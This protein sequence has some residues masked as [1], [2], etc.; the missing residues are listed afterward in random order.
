ML[1][2]DYYVDAA[3]DIL[4]L[5]SQLDE[6]V[7][8]DMV[9]RMVRMGDVTSATVWQAE[10]LQEAGMLYDDIIRR[11]AEIT[12][13]ST[14]QVQ[15]MFEDAGIRSIEYDAAIYERAGLTPVPIR[16]SPEAAQRLLAGIRKTQGHLGNLSLTTATTAQSAYIQAVTLAEMQ[17]E[18]GVM[19]YATAIRNAVRSAAEQGTVVLYPTGHRDK[20]DVA[21]RRAVLTGA[22]QTASQIS[23][24]YAADMGCDLVETTAHAGARPS[25]AVW[26]GRVFSISGNHPRYGDF[27]DATGYGTGGGLCGWNCRHS[28]F[29][30]FEGLSR[31]TYGRDRLQEYDSRTVTYNGDTMPYYDAT[32]VQRGLERKVRDTKRTLA[33]LDEGVKSADNDK[34]RNA[35]RKEFEAESVRLKS[36]EAKLKD[37]LAQTDL[38]RQKER[39]QVLAWGRSTAQKAVWADRRVQ[40][41]RADDIIIAEAKK[42]SGIRGKMELHPKTTDMPHMTVDTEHIRKRG[43][44]VTAE[45]AHEY[46]ANARVKVT[47]WGG[48]FENYYSDGGAAYVD[49]ANAQ[50]R[51]AFSAEEYADTMKAMM[52]GLRKHGK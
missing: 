28:F 16:Q 44:E 22:S 30:F 36:Q 2:P 23:L 15:A 31:R 49:V 13:A 37:F 29:P 21:V 9:R 34:V 20:L 10:R 18:S 33:G 4:A 32:Q 45:Q 14:A 46:I 17:V 24:G 35:L 27:Y 43:H 48:R 11:V 5:Y 42:A 8:R 52:E 47:R 6:A 25:H 51:T 26:Q 39:E 7:I 3:E 12:D 50:I 40:S 1:P 19:D 41:K 38:V